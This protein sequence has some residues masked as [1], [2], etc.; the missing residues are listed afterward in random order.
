M[1]REVNLVLSP[2]QSTDNNYITGAAARKAGVD[3]SSLA[4]SRIIRKSIDAR[5][6]E[7]K[8][9]LAVL[10][11]SGE[12]N[13]DPVV[14]EFMWKNVSNA[15][16]VIIVG[17]GP[18]GLFAALELIRNG[19][20]P[21]IL[22]RGREV[23]ARK[24]DIAQISREHKV[25]PDSNYCFGEGGAGTFSDGKLYTRSKK[26]GD[27]RDVLELLCFH[28]A[29]RSIL[30]DAHPHIGTD[31]LPAVITAIR[32]T[33]T[34]SGGIV[35]FNRRVNALIVEGGKIR[36][37]RVTG[38]ESFTASRVILATGHSARDVYTL[39]TDAGISL[40]AK[41]FAMGVRVEHP[42]T[43]IDNIQ[44]HTANRGAFLPAA[45]YS[46][47]TQCGGRG[48]YSFCMC[49][50]GFIVPAATN[51]GEV[52]VNGMSPSHRNSPYANSGI[53]VEITLADIP[54][55]FSGDDNLG[56]LRYQSWLES[57]AC[58]NGNGSQAVPAQR[59]DDFIKGRHSPTLPKVSYFPGVISS[60]LDR[61]LPP[62]I[63]SRLTEAF[64]IFEH[65]MKGFVTGEA[66]VTGVESR[67]SSPVRIPRDNDRMMQVSVEGLYPAGEGAGYAGGILSS[68]IDG[69]R[70]AQAIAR[71]A[72][73]S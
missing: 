67:S 26:R 19:L 27:N 24:K 69:I 45:S 9:N 37:V 60:P 30:Y 10:I 7:I 50:G 58:I 40:E 38:G 54:R 41:P 2:Q 44:Y 11:W 6:R 55:E 61:W 71:E 14:P 15:E 29:D 4:G 46:L 62:F 22:E 73:S 36:G 28:G 35:L 49:P 64:G 52:V 42:Q 59:L 34:S 51:A 18:A 53:I 20:K 47:A 16:E 43:L 13:P 33:I 21:V 3:V 68:A 32:E 63:K 72:I 31:R 5:Q 8:V 17:S 48:V 66:V 1:I 12:E 23:S 70:V 56:G 57:Q 25:N 39:L 65:K